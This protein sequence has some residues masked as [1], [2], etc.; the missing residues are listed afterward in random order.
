MIYSYHS[1]FSVHRLT[2]TERQTW[3]EKIQQYQ[4]YVN[5]GIDVLRRIKSMI[6]RVP[7]LGDW[8]KS[9]TLV[10]YATQVEKIIDVLVKFASVLQKAHEEVKNWRS[11][12]QLSTQLPS[13]PKLIPPTS[14][15]DILSWLKIN[16][17]TI[18]QVLDIFAQFF[19]QLQLI[20]SV[21][22]IVQYLYRERKNSDKK[23]VKAHL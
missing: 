12:S 7:V 14:H 13:L 21:L 3:L 18:K 1:L 17:D 9:K 8:L 15:E 6:E 22:P 4:E 20:T 11:P 19:P 23:I 2:S 5:Q 16:W 10:K